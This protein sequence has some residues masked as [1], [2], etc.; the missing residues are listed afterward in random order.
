MEEL[1]TRLRDGTRVLLRPI[2]PEDKD[3]LREGLRL[4]SPES[5]YLR[6]HSPVTKLTDEQLRYLTEIDYHD[7]MAWVALDE[8]N[9][10]VPGI[11]VARYVRLADEPTIAEAAVTVLDAYQGRG[12]GTLLLGLLARSARAAGI[13]T[14]RNY[15]LLENDAML[16]LFDQLGATRVDEG[17]GVYRVDMPVEEDSHEV[18]DTPAGRAFK[19]VARGRLPRFG[20]VNPGAWLRRLLEDR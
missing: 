10:D 11:G 13:D 9:P 16:D 15:V 5:R 18:G 7:H 8:D 4:L 3:R 14:F 2:L 17:G 12:V 19:E 6:F 20:L 1:E